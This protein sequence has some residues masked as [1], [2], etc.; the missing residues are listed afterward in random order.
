MKLTAILLL[1]AALTFAQAAPVTLSLSQSA[2]AAPA[3]AL[4][5]ASTTQPAGVQFSLIYS[6]AGIAAVN[7]T[8]GP[9]AVAAGKTI[10]CASSPGSTICVVAGINSNTI[11]DGVLAQIAVTPTT[12]V[13]PVSVMLT[14]A[15]S[16]SLAGDALATTGSGMTFQLY[17]PFDLNRDGKID[18][19]DL[20]I[21]IDAI[22][23]QQA[24]GDLNH[25]GAENIIDVQA[26]VI[27]A[28][29]K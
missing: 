25:D 21:L 5:I 10:T 2:S 16:A 13:G 4:S 9:A 24:A 12:Y 29:G 28:L 6:A 18:L 17:S 15:L 20:R 22:L 14:G 27:A 11:A 1:T 23:A 26:L 7:V 19:T 8:A 3:I